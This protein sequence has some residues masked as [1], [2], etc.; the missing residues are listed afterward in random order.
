MTTDARTY[1]FAD[2]QRPGLLLGLSAR[3]AVPVIGGVLILA[4]SLQSPLPAAVGLVGPIMGTAVAFGRWQGAPLSETLI[5]GTRLWLARLVGRHRW[6]RP[7]LLG[8]NTSGALPRPLRGL[9]LLEQ[10]EA[11]TAVVRDRRAGTVTAVLRVRGHGFPLSSRAEQDALLAAW[12]AAL[13]PF[14]RE[15]SPISAVTW[16]EWAHPVGADDHRSFLTSTGVHERS[17]ETAAS[18]YLAL[19]DQQAPQTVAHD[20]LVS[21]TVDQRRVRVRRGGGGRL[22]AALDALE[23]ELRLFASRLDAAGLSVS[24]PLSPVEVSTAVRVRSDPSRS[25][26]VATLSRSLA[27]AARRGALEWGPMLVETSRTQVLVDGTFHRSFRIAGWPQLPVAADW[28]SDLLTTTPAVRTV[29]VVMEPVPMGRAA[30]AADRE[31]MAREAD[32]D[33]KTQKG[34][35]VNA[36]ERKRLADVEARERELS[37]GHAEFSFVGIV[38]VTATDLDQLDD[39][40][41]DVEQAAAQSLLD[42]RPLDARHDQGWV[43]SLP[44]GRGLA[45]TVG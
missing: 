38:D 5:P 37:E 36:R 10:T 40:C 20:I 34:F 28:M 7:P 29:T 16:Q 24:G 18:D 13:S 32:A 3:Q 33:M 12:S 19:I 41:A 14:A 30:R 15:R 4:A 11:D 17:G 43:A 2:S 31:V 39:A 27:A 22:D 35:R 6:M 44:L 23:G 9:E 1:R 45:R 25:R 42:L 21:V 26:Q 8:D